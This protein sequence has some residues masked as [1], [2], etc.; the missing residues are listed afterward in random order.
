MRRKLYPDG[1]PDLLLSLQNLSDLRARQG[2]SVEA[3]AL[4]QEA[5][6]LTKRLQENQ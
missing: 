5:A 4:L 2:D 6:D 1:H 3:A